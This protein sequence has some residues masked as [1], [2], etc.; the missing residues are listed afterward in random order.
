MYSWDMLVEDPYPLAELED[1]SIHIGHEQENQCTFCGKDEDGPWYPV[2]AVSIIRHW[3]IDSTDEPGGGHWTWYCPQHL[4]RRRG[5]WWK[6]SHLAPERLMP[7][8]RHKCSHVFGASMK[9]GDPAVEP[10]DGSW[11]CDT[12]AAS[13]RLKRKQMAVFAQ[14]DEDEGLLG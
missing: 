4:E 10:F 13:A 12:H 6:S 5:N 7:E 9:C 8:V 1:R 2:E 3:N 11:L 14:D